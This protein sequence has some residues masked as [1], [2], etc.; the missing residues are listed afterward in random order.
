MAFWSHFGV[1]VVVVVVVGVVIVV[2]VVVVVVVGRVMDSSF[3]LWKIQGETTAFF[4]FVVS[5]PS[6]E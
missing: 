3:V 5:G 2:V 1:V 6:G 4:V